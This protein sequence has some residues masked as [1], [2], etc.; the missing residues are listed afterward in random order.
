MS[1]EIFPVIQTF[2]KMD[3][4]KILMKAEWKIRSLIIE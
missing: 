4:I 1:E 3:M 2:N